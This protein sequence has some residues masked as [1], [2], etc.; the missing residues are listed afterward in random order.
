MGARERKRRRE[1]DGRE[2]E[3]TKWE[4]GKNANSVTKLTI[5]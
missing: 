1:E 2:E 4:G 5:G 3:Y